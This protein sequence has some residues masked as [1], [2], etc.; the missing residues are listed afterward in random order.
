MEAQEDTGRPCMWMMNVFYNRVLPV[1]ME[2]HQCFLASDLNF[3]GVMPI[4]PRSY[5]IFME[6]REA[7]AAQI[8]AELL[9]V[10]PWTAMLM[11]EEGERC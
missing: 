3:A 11:T 5:F 9:V 4:V 10:S 6:K 2:L 1:R 8:N 7:F